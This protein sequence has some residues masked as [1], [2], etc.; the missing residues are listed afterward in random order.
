M[1]MYASIVGSRQARRSF[2]SEVIVP[3]GAVISLRLQTAPLESGA[4]NRRDRDRSFPAFQ[5]IPYRHARFEPR[6]LHASR[7]GTLSVVCSWVQKLMS[8][9]RP[10]IRSLRPIAHLLSIRFCV[11]ISA[12]RPDSQYCLPFAKWLLPYKFR[13]L[14]CLLSGPGLQRTTDTHPW[15]TSM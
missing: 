1:S 2:F 10:I 8:I 3:Q 7:R 15:L 11:V 14:E 6:V 5:P 9:V 4:S 12:V 13:R